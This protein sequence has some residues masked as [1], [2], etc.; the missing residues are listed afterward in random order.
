MDNWERKKRLVGE[1]KRL[2]W[3]AGRISGRVDRC[4]YGSER[5][6]KLQLM[7]N[8]IELLVDNLIIELLEIK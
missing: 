8:E 5:Y 2:M 3:Q 6:N 7:C 1:I 4:K